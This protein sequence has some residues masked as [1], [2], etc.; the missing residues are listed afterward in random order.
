MSSLRYDPIHDSRVDIL[1]LIDQPLRPFTP[2][3]SLQIPAQHT[4]PNISGLDTEDELPPPSE[5]AIYP[6]S[7][8]DGVSKA[9]DTLS[10]Q[11]NTPKKPSVSFAKRANQT[12]LISAKQQHIK[13][14]DG[15]PLWRKDVQYTFL[16]CVFHDQT[17]AFSSPFQSGEK[18]TFGELYVQTIAH[19]TKTLKILRERLLS[20][21]GMA[22]PV[23]MVSL[24]VNVGRMNTT[25]NFVPEMKSQL[26]TFH[27]IPVLQQGKENGSNKTL[28]DL[29]RLKSLLKSWSE[30]LKHP[31]K[32]LELFEVPKNVFPKTNVINMIF[33][34]C[35][36][37]HLILQHFQES[38]LRQHKAKQFSYDQSHLWNDDL[39][40]PSQ[41]PFNCIFLNFSTTPQSRARRFLWILYSYL[42][43]N[44]TYE[45]AIKNPFLENEASVEIPK[46]EPVP[47]GVEY[48]IDTPDELAYGQSMLEARKAILGEEKEESVDPKSSKVSDDDTPLDFKRRRLEVGNVKYLDHVLR[49]ESPA[50]DDQGEFEGACARMFE[51]AGHLFRQRF[52]GGL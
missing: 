15:E 44:L 9:P 33:M 7:A 52:L 26:R 38:T 10:S 46:L 11:L 24:L 23:C 16:S 32:F 42:E 4:T 45:E 29:P 21:P 43:T 41:L 8:P 40:N 13:K 20:D 34:L 35:A 49:G 37:E 12:L 22:I 19:L 50:L 14:L 5:R 48:D 31:T 36:Y 47:E 2:S 27:L 18:L 39:T 3:N 17:K 28:Q 30:P 6:A 25:V 1:N 51:K